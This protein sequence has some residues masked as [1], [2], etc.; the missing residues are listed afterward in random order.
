[1]PQINLGFGTTQAF[2]HGWPGSELHINGVRYTKVIEVTGDQPTEREA[3]H[4]TQALPVDQTLGVA[5]LGTGKIMFS[6][7]EERVRLF[8]NI[9]DGYREVIFP[10]LWILRS[11]GKPDI[12][13]EYIGAAITS[14]PVEHSRGAAALGGEVN[15]TFMEK[16]ING[17]SAHKKASGGGVLGG[18]GIGVGL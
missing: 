10:I 13:Y 8:T 11:K 3:V 5:E 16:K 6:A 18:S 15:F 4:G 1:M 7:E 17:L 14:D 2:A 9:G 12:R